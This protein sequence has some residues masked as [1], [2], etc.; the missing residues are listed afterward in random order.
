MTDHRLVEAIDLAPTFIEAV[1]GAPPSHILEGRSLLA[2]TRHAAAGTAAPWRSAAISECDYAFR[3]ARRDLKLPV[4]GAR[5][6]MLCTERFKYLLFPPFRPQLFD[7]E[8]D[9]HELNDLGRSRAYAKTRAKLHEQLFCWL[10]G[11]KMRLTMPNSVI[12]RATGGH[13][14]RG[15]LFGVW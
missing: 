5:G 12:E 2:A 13:K 14:R 7:L 15:F 11:R 9:P 4:D 3:V 10:R 1:G 6:Y 8:K